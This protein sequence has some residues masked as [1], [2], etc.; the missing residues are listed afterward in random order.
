MN[1]QRLTNNPHTATTN[2]PWTHRV[3]GS[4][5]RTTNKKTVLLVS[6]PNIEHMPL[7]KK[8][9]G[10]MIGLLAVYVAAVLVG[11]TAYAAYNNEEPRFAAIWSFVTATLV[12]SA[13]ELTTCR[14]SK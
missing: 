2:L 8:S 13:Y 12:F 9:L 14:C 6:K 5:R 1:A 10:Y 3:P 4:V 11:M 7:S